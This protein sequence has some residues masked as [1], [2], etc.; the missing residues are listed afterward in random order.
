MQGLQ[1]KLGDSLTKIKD[2]LDQGKQKLQTVQEISELKRE[3]AQALQEKM[4]ALVEIGHICYTLI[5][6]NQIQNELFQP[7][8]ERIINQ[9]QLL[10]QISKKIAELQPTEGKNTCQCG[11]VLQKSDKFCGSCGAKVSLSEPPASMETICC[12]TCKVGSTLHAKYCFCCGTKLG[13]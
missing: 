6:Q 7:L 2:G 3:Q 5:R 8:C 1:T 9:D 12:P 4:Q 10:Y 11:E 13:A